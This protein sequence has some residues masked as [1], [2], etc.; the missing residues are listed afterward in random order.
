MSPSKDER[1]GVALCLSGRGYQGMLFQAGCLSRLNQLG[2][3][4]RLDCIASV[5]GGA[6][7]AAALGVAWPTLAFDRNGIATNFSALVLDPLRCLASETIEEWS[8]LGAAFSPASPGEIIADALDEH[9]LAGRRLADLPDDTDGGAPAFVFGASAA[10]SGAL[11]AFSRSGCRDARGG[12]PA[13]AQLRIALAAAASVSLPPWLSTLLPMRSAQRIAL[14]DG[15]VAD[16]L[17]TG[18]VPGC[19]RILLVSDGDSGVI[20]PPVPSDCTLDAARVVDV[21]SGQLRASQRRELLNA[22][23]RRHGDG[24]RAGV[25]WNMSGA[26]SGAG[27]AVGASPSIATASAPALHAIDASEQAALIGWGEAVCGAALSH[28]LAAKAAAP[29]HYFQLPPSPISA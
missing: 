10:D 20:R 19:C 6:L 11:V 12:A 22:L 2:W 4:R 3:L 18:A 28:W 8:I 5:S 16:S 17:A 1:T 23:D 29:A 21:I 14:I 24:G 26:S 27:R 9:L 25:Y 7:A 13:H 15:S